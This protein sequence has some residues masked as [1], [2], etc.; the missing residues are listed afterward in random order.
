MANVAPCQS[1][2]MPPDPTTGNHSDIHLYTPSVVGFVGGWYRPPGSTRKHTW[3]GPRDPEG[4]MLEHAAALF[5]TKTVEADRVNATVTVKNVGAGH[6]IPTG[7]PLRHMLLTVSARCG[8]TSLPVIEAPVVPAYGG[9]RARKPS[10][11]DWTRWPEAQPGDI[12]RVVRR[13]GGFVDYDGVGPF[14]DGTFSASE[15]GLAVERFV[16]EATIVSI[17]AGVATF[18]RP[19]GSGDEAYLVRGQEDLAGRPGFAFARVLADAGGD[20]M[21]PHFQ[22]VDVVSDNR[23]MPQR[24]FTASFAFE[25]TCTDPRIDARLVYRRFPVRLARARRW[26]LETQQMTEGTR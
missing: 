10:G 7:E 17:S 4:R 20:T 24:S 14:G 21:V 22:A 23:L 3:P 5:V 12:V 1:C 13:P 19:L 18:D 16:E 6:A 11:A 2:H 9:Y 8:V 26:P 15:K 25:T